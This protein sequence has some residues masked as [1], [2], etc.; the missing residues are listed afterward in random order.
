MDLENDF[1][2]IL[3]DFKEELLTIRT[4]RPTPKLIEDVPVTYMEQKMTVKQLG[5]INIEPPRDL[6]INIWDENA[7]NAV[8]AGLVAANLGVNVSPQGKSVR[9][10]LPELTQQRKEELIKIVKS[11]GE[12]A[13]IKMRVRREDLQK[14][15]K[16]IKDEDDMF[17]AKEDLQKQVD[18]FNKAIDE[19]VEIKSADILE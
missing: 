7:V 9:V 5:S 13:R 14:E 3:E 18:K 2:K 12:Q 8:N 10:T 11:M 1:G 4:N 19:A 16:E 17:K 6:V 15:I